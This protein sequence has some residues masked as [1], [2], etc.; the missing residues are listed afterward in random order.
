MKK[1]KV[2]SEKLLVS[3]AY[4]RVWDDECA[5]TLSTVSLAKFP[6]RIG[7]FSMCAESHSAFLMAVL[8]EVERRVWRLA[9][10]AR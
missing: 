4:Q 7:K 3:R 9:L 8:T 6:S 2:E 1:G 5:Y 10:K